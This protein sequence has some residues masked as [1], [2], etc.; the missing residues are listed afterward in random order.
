MAQLKVSWTKT[1][2]RQRNDV[3][4]YWNERNKNTNYSKKLYAK[5]SERISLLKSHPKSGRQSEFEDVRVLSLNHYSIL[6]KF[7]GLQIIVVGFWDNRRNPSELLKFLQ[8]Y[9]DKTP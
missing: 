8:T 9:N 2:V 1:A 7:D 4:E 5:I 6:F 3:F